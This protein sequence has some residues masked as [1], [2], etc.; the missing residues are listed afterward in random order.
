MVRL[1]IPPLPQPTASTLVV[2]DFV[3]QCCIDGLSALVRGPLMQDMHQ[4]SAKH[5]AEA[6]RGTSGRRAGRQ[7]LPAEQPGAAVSRHPF[8]C[9]TCCGQR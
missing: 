3:F 5:G 9:E 8:N 6:F 1:Y 7:A 4:L 2:V